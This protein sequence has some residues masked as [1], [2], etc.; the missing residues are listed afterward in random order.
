MPRKDW[1]AKST[2]RLEH[3]VRYPDIYRVTKPEK[4]PYMSSLLA[5]QSTYNIGEKLQN[6]KNGEVLEFKGWDKKSIIKIEKTDNDP[7]LKL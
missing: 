6:M 7:K 1:S 4:E 2:S 3:N 5:L